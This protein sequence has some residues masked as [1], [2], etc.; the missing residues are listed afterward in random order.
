MVGTPRVAI[1]GAGLSGLCM[2]IRLEQTG[3]ASFT[4]FEKGEGVGGTWR[5][6][7]YPGA[8]CDVPSH[9]Y[10]FSFL[11]S[12]DWSRHYAEQPEILRYLEHCVDR[13]GLRDRIRFGTEIIAARFDDDALAWRLEAR[14]GRVFTADVLVA[15]LGQLNRPST[16]RIAGL[17]AFAG[18]VFHSARWDHSRDL[19]GR[20]VAVVGTGASAVQFVP[21]IAP[22][23]GRLSVFQRSPNWILP[24][25]DAAYSERAKRAFRRVPALQRLHRA[26]IYLG[27]EARFL[28]LEGRGQ[29][30]VGPIMQRLALRH[31]EAQILDP[32]L[33]SKLVPSYPIG[34]KRVLVSDD[35]YPALARPNVE[36]I[37]ASIESITHDAVVTTGGTRWPV[38]TIVLGTGFES[39]DFLA[40]LEI[41]G[42][43]GQ[44]I[45]D[46]WRDGAEAY[47]GMT[48][49]GFPNLFILY[50]P[51]TNLGHNS[52]VFMVECQVGYILRC[53]AQLRTRAP[54]RVSMEVRRDVMDAYNRDVQTRMRSTVWEAGCD[55]WY[56]TASGKV[57]NNWPRFTFQYLL[58]TRTARGDD[59]VWQVRR[60]ERD[61][62][63]R[64]GRSEEP[65]DARLSV[66]R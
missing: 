35:Y 49:A 40:P 7:G 44:R 57:T 58:A 32:V 66:P 27:S 33:R 8:G 63:G 23:V 31:L 29:H 45:A 3:V 11:P 39:R 13:F 30:V 19:A 54:G 28:G 51:N 37:T 22:R 52:I 48:V 65:S 21:R 9:L 25:N 47:L 15:G 55:S 14:D 36:L 41:V 26:A 43:G 24:R 53:I 56:K 46:A 16:P 17:D 20:H 34:C 38:D 61:R 59:F 50:G 10:S 2:A 6:N 12:P 42:T 62:S 1:L 60:D 64:S 5:D 18:R 4:I